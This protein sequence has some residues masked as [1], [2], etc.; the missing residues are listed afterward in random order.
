MSQ[1]F[2][3]GGQS[4]GVFSLNVCQQLSTTTALIHFLS[5]ILLLLVLIG[6][7]QFLSFSVLSIL[8]SIILRHTSVLCLILTCLKFFPC[9]PYLPGKIHTSEARTTLLL[10][11][12]TSLA[13]SPQ[14][15]PLSQVLWQNQ[16]HL[17]PLSCTYSSL[18]F[19][20][21][22]FS[23]LQLKHHPYHVECKCSL[24]FSDQIWC[25]LIHNISLI[26]PC[27]WD[28]SNPLPQPEWKN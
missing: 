22:T 20:F 19:C 21:C 26:S 4:L 5:S 11:D 23:S 14:R 3:S 24:S 2:T 28:Q 6:S 15:S 9:S 25:R 10:L 13:H 16:V 7:P 8:I 27:K 17:L 18:P 1:L 12:T